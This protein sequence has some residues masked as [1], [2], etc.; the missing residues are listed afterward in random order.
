MTHQES[1]TLAVVK[2]DKNKT[3]PAQHKIDFYD[4]HTYEDFW[5]GRDYEH[6][7]EVIAIKRL[8]GDEHFQTALDYGGGYGRLAFLL[9]AYADNIVL[10]DP[11]QRHLDIAGQ[12]LKSL[13]QLN[14]LHLEQ[15]GMIPLPDNTLEL[16][17]MVRVSHHLRNPSKNFREI[18]RVLKPGGKVIIEI[19]NSAHALNR[20]KYLAK[21]KR[22]PKSPIKL[23]KLANGLQDPTPFLNHH[24]GT[25]E[26][27]LRNDGFKVL[28]K[29]SV[30][31]LRNGFL[32]RSLPLYGLLGMEQF[33]Q[34]RLAPFNFGPSIFFYAKK[35]KKL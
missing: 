13:P 5:I 2:G 29:L 32:K 9:A 7:A 26:V 23:G 4:E 11:S 22:V 1:S 31:N 21:L 28:D 10:A 3:L 14:L 15:N 27:A 8:L 20:L 18:W 30:S 34:A 12:R 19:A 17:V 33:L 35:N 24:A 6:L 25:I 16:V